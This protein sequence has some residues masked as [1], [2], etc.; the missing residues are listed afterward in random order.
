MSFKTNRI[1]SPERILIKILALI[2]LIRRTDSYMHVACRTSDDHICIFPFEY[3][4]TLYT[5]CT[6]AEI[7]NVNWKD[8][9]P[10]QRR[11][12]CA[13][14]VDKESKVMQKW[15]YCNEHCS[16]KSIPAWIVVL[17][18]GVLVGIGLVSCIADYGGYMNSCRKI[19]TM[20]L[21]GRRR[22]QTT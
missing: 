13:Y 9:H 11:P 20:K 4:G 6:F 1:I 5:K 16:V 2:S 15:D 21:S 22:N 10:K 18:V 3:Q 12:W 17:A 8:R 14:K 7:E 19:I